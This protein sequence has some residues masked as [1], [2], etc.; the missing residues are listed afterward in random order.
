M[1]KLVWDE[2]GK[3]IYE[4]GVDHG[5]LFVLDSAG[6][7]KPG[8]AWN[9]LTSV[10]EN[11]SGADANPI[12]ADNI[13]YLNIISAEEFG[14]TVEAYTYPDE[15]MACDGSAPIG[16]ASSGVFAGQ[17]GRAKFGL[18]YRTRIG[19]DVAGDQLGYKIHIIYNCSAS[20]SAKSYQTVNDSPEAISFSW[21]ITTT[22]VPVASTGKP[23]ANIVIDSTKVEPTALAAIEAAL[24][25][26]DGAQDNATLLLPDAIVTLLTA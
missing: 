4:T 24:F 21:E 22:P 20:P 3:H 23:T 15:F 7:Y 17:Q 6:Q 8:I 5:V 1:S 9:G 25:G 19:N 16:G 13:K 11:P 10:A 12:Y 18:V 26:G 14:A 2:S